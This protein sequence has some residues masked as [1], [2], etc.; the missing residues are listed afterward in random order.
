LL[1]R[2]SD[3]FDYFKISAADTT[4]GKALAKETHALVAGMMD[5]EDVYALTAS[6]LHTRP[7]KIF[8]I[9][10]YLGSS[11]NFFLNLLPKSKVISIAFVREPGQA[12]NNDD[13]T[14][15]QVGSAVTTENR[16]RFT[17]LIGDSHQIVAADFTAKHGK[18]DFVFVD[19]DHSRAGVAQD[20]ELAKKLI[21]ASGAIGW[22]D[23]NPKRRYKD[24][25]LFL[26]EDLDLHAIATRDDFIGGVAFWSKKIE[27]KLKSKAATA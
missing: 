16:A 2:V 9:G 13:L 11:S 10:T 22:H 8:E 24:V 21:S 23:A 17:Q 25:R 14:L 12:Y 20:T 18:M 26:E 4:R 1:T 27:Q 3:W 6:L 15:E 5:I 19:G 7:A